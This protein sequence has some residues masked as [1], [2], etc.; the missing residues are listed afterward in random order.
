MTMKSGSLKKP[1]LLGAGV[2]LLTA[3]ASTFA[4]DM[5]EAASTGWATQNGGTKGGAAAASANI[6][7]VR[8]PMT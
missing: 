8:T 5:R 7:T 3:A 4:A 2:V 6:Y 1:A